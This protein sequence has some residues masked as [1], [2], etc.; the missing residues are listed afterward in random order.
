MNKKRNIK[1][2]KFSNKEKTRENSD[3]QSLYDKRINDLLHIIEFKNY[4]PNEAYKTIMKLQ[5]FLRKRR[6]LKE[7]GN[8]YIP[9]TETGKLII[10]GKIKEK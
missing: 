5:M 10:N 3:L 1:G 2:V 4:K 7:S 6:S 9:R 8:I